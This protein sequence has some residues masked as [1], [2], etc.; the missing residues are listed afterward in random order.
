MKTKTLTVVCLAYLFRFGT[1]F[2][3]AQE[4]TPNQPAKFIHITQ[5]IVKEGSFPE[6]ESLQVERAKA[7]YAANWPQVLI[8]LKTITGPDLEVLRISFFNS[9]EE[10]ANE[11]KEMGKQSALSAKL[12]EIAQKESLLLQSRREIDAHYQPKISYQGNFN[13]ADMRFMSIISIHLKPGHGSEYLQN[14]AIVLKA[15]S[16][17]KLPENLA[18]YT[19]YSGALSSTYL[20]MRPVTSL[21]G[22]DEM[23]AMHGDAYGAVLGDENREK[24]HELFAASVETEEEDYFGFDHVLSYTTA[25]WAGTNSDYWKPSAQN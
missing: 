3:L 16:E 23:E 19:V 14:R 7:L 13:W 25:A 10:R 21:K 8:A 4:G 5:D 20:I 6:Y 2:C 11:K 9:F 22:F 1:T 15:H 24:V 17:A 12:K 18:I